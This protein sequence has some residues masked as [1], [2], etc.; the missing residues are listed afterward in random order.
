MRHFLSIDALEAGVLADLL[1]VARYLKRRRAAGMSEH[2]LAGKTLAMVFEKPSLRTRISFEVAMTELGGRAMYIR[3]EEIGIGKREAIQ[4]VARVLG[5]MVQGIMARVY[6]NETVTAL[7]EHSGVPVINGL[8]DLHHPCQAL[9]DLLT[10]VE[11]FG[12]AKGL[13]VAFIGDGNNVSRSLAQICALAGAE[14]VLACPEGYEF[15]AAELE[16][17]SGVTMVRD[18]RQAA[19]GA[20]VL[21]TDVWTSMGQEA[22]REERLKDFA[23]YQVNEAL[24]S[25]ARPDAVVMHCLPAHRGEEISDGAMDHPRSIVIDQAEN[26]LH[27][28]KALLRLML[29]DDASAVIA[30]AAPC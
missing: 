9:G 11:R 3:G 1:L 29:A 16:G 15:T 22:E 20:H 2:A 28:Q 4:D 5:R 17:V 13:K 14:F 21:Y 24:L 8:C 26:R 10:I 19:A 25:A 6:R 30:A 12:D 27:A 23:A 18:P 7:A